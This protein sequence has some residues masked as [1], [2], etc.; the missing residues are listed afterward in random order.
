MKHAA[1]ASTDHPATR[2][3]ESQ[4]RRRWR[5]RRRRAIAIV[6]VVFVVIDI[7]LSGRFRVGFVV[8]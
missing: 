6:I 5:R 8:G 3:H 2:S 7:V 4:I 1:R